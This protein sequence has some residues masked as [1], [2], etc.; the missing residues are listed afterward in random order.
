VH[1]FTNTDFLG[2]PIYRNDTFIPDSKEVSRRLDTYYW[3]YY[4]KIETLLSERKSQ[5]GNALLWDAH[6]I[7]SYVPSIRKE[8]FPDL[9]LGN[10]DHKTAHPELTKSA[11]KGLQSGDYEVN[12]NDPF[13]G[14]HITRYFGKPENNIHALQLEMNKVLY[15]DDRELTFNE[16]RANK[17]EVVLKRTL[18]DVIKTI[19][20]L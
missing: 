16:E 8:K 4:Q 17:M 6:S 3:P 18:Q 13:K 20:Q 2:N 19:H 1:L 7:R 9:I 11:I 5:F 15:M 10:N 12:I 14:G